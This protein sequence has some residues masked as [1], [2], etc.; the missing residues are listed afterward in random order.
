MQSFT[1]EELVDAFQKLDL[2]L[3]TTVVLDKVKF[4]CDSLNIT[5]TDMVYKLDA[6]CGQENNLDL[7]KFGKFEK[8]VRDN[9]SKTPAKTV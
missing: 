8:Y 4:L 3:P 1:S 2:P 9:A 6:F 7:G 5:P